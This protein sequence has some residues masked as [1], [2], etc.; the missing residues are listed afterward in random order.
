[1]TRKCRLL[2]PIHLC[3]LSLTFS[4]HLSRLFTHSEAPFW[5]ARNQCRFR[6]LHSDYPLYFMSFELSAVDLNKAADRGRYCL[7]AAST[8]AVGSQL[9]LKAQ[10]PRGQP[11]ARYSFGVLLHSRLLS[12][13]SSMVGIR[14]ALRWLLGRSSFVDTVS[15]RQAV[16]VVV[17]C[18]VPMFLGLFGFP[19]YGSCCSTRILLRFS[20]GNFSIAPTTLQALWAGTCLL[21][22]GKHR[23]NNHDF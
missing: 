10:H 17:A 18:P 13:R 3:D 14:S 9:F 8:C 22:A 7:L 23:T 16:A 6:L 20:D 12:K 15:S 4:R 2:A 21:T 19:V 1:M 5:T 11:F